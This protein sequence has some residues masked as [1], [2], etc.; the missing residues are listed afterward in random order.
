MENITIKNV[1]KNEDGFFIEGVE[2]RVFFLP[3]EK[4]GEITPK[5]GDSLTLYTYCGCFIRG[6]KLNSTSLFYQ[7]EEEL[8]KEH[9]E[10]ANH[11][12]QKLEEAYKYNQADYDKVFAFLPK[13]LQYRIEL[14]R[15]F[16]PDFRLK[17]EGYELSTVFLAN[18]IYHHCKA[19]NIEDFSSNVDKFNI[20]KYLNSH[21][22]FSTRQ[23]SCSQVDYA[24]SLATVLFR[25]A[26]EQKIDIG[27]PSFDDLLISLTLKMPDAMSIL[28]KPLCWPREN[29]IKDYISLFN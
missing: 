23:V 12:Q 2:G 22:Y 24:K 28:K 27:N 7:T 3:K 5:I 26:I 17:D 1:T 18:K 11:Q 10:V 9:Q 29:Y 21:W 16:S 13:L 14:F 8:Q 6:V 25:D 15:K 19:S 4:T 20:K